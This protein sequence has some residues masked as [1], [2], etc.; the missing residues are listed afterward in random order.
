MALPAL[1][2]NMNL[3]NE[4]QSWLGEVAAVT[5]PTLTRKLEEYRGG[6]MDGPVKYDMGG[7]ALEQEATFGGPM[8]DILRQFGHT[9]ASGIYQRFVGF[10]QDDSTSRAA[11]IEI[12]TRGRHEEIEMG[13]QKPGEP[14]EFKVKSTLTYY[15]LDWDGA[16]IIEIDRL[17]MV[18]MV[19]GIDRLAEQR[20]AIL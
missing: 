18:F 20:A 15:R 5:I 19:D 11:T 12:T 1:L 8:R 6:A 13:E 9:S 10:Y 2:K 16:T 3:F 14:G 4:G 17:N 7:E